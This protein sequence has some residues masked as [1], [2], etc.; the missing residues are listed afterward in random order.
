MCD[1]FFAD[2]FGWS[3]GGGEREREMFSHSSSFGHPCQ[4]H[5]TIISHHVLSL[6]HSLHEGTI[7]EHH[8]IMFN[9]HNNNNHG[10]PQS[11]SLRF[12]IALPC[13]PTSSPIM[14]TT[15]PRL[16]N[17]NSKHHITPACMHA[18]SHSASRPVLSYST[19]G[20]IATLQ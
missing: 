17:R 20:I 4:F 10:D 9:H 15:Q 6:Y 12:T 19:P 13:P 2:M 1:Y 11:T 3:L 7:N 14:N 16:Q 8:H 18:Q 5:L